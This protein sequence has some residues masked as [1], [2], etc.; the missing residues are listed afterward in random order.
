MV[1]IVG[2]KV[3]V[4]E[5][6]GIVSDGVSVVSEVLSGV[7]VAVGGFCSRTRLEFQSMTIPRQ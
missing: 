2:V 1:V 4:G 3:T 6:T 5:I 7:R